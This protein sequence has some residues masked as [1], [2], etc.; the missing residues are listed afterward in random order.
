[1]KHDLGTQAKAVEPSCSPCNGEQTHHAGQINLAIPPG[2][3]SPGI[4]DVL[5]VLGESQLWLEDSLL[6]SHELLDLGFCSET[7]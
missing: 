3:S 7:L 6:E 1:M 2:P 5:K 4:L